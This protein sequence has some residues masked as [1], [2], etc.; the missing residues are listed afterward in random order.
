MYQNGIQT[1][2]K[3][4]Y[5]DRNHIKNNWDG[6]VYLESNSKWP[7]ERVPSTEL[8]ISV[9]LTSLLSEL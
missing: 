5:A 3:V 8:D 7:E 1:Q 6:N 4:C 2:A 9:Q